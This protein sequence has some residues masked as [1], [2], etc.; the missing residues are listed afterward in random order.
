MIGSATVREHFPTHEISWMVTILFMA[1]NVDKICNQIKKQFTQFL[2]V[3]YNLSMRTSLYEDLYSK[4]TD[5]IRAGRLKAGSKMPSVRRCAEENGVSRNT[6]LGAYALLLSEGYINSRERSGYFV[7]NFES[8]IP[9]FTVAKRKVPPKREEIKANITDLSA[10]LIDSSLF[11][12][13]TLRQ[14]YRETLSG[15]N[16]SIL[17]QSGMNMGDED[18]RLSISDYVY[19]HKGIS[20]SEDQIIIGNGTSY[21]LQALPSLFEEKPVF[22]MENPG[23]ASTREIVSDTGCEIRDISLDDEGASIKDIRRKTTGLQGNIL[24]HISPSHQYPMGTT[25]SAP[26][27]AAVLDWAKAQDGRYVIEDDYDSDFRYNGH[28]I[29]SVCGM[30]TDGKVIYIGTFSRTLT[31]SIRLS[32]MILPPA[33]LEK[34]RK[35]FSKY[36]CPVSRIDQK[37]VSLFMDNGFFERHISRM[38]RVYRSRRNRMLE[39]IQSA[40]PSAEIKGEE[41]GLHFIVRFPLPEKDVISRALGSGFR[42]QGTGTGW[43]VIG[44]AHLSDEQTERFYTFLRTLMPLEQT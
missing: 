35:R 22:L 27:R 37:V 42:L 44:Y 3:Q 6:V 7:A 8:P 30:D 21:H 19:N 10:N 33:L 23:F 38:R 41:A 31:P 26:R 11:P 2:W 17:G 12:Y 39:V 1:E 29:A 36:P 14:L 20:C 34:Y 25:M 9:S 13:S 15:Q 43:I 28:P 16:I 18:I 5:E 4:F 32:Y 24:L 40:V